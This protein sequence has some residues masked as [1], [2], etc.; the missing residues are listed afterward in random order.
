MEKTIRKALVEKERDFRI[1]AELWHTANCLLRAGQQPK[2]SSA[3]EFRA[4]LIFRAFY[5]EAFLNWLG[6][7]L[8]PH[9]K[10]LERLKPREKLDLLADLIQVK[11]DY[12]GRLWQIVK[13][14][15]EFRNAVAHGEPETLKSESYEDLNA[16]LSGKIDFVQT[17]WASLGT[18][19]Y[20]VRANEDVEKIANILYEKANLKHKG[21]LGPFS[22]G[23]QIRHASL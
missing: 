14:L 20:A 13:E 22:F 4:S 19:E 11:P 1:H 16:F 12:G 6:P 2:E 21:P 5:V 8:I 23:F 15:F 17:D 9:W 10:Y 3:H 7:Q 18:E